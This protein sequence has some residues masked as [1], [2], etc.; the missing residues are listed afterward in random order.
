MI[1]SDS[2][3]LRKYARV[4]VF[5]LCA[6]AMGIVCF[7]ISVQ[8]SVD[9]NSGKRLLINLSRQSE[10][11]NDT[12]NLHFQFLD[13]IAMKLAESDDLLSDANFDMISYVVDSTNFDRVAIIDGDGNSYYSDG[14]TSNVAAR[15]YFQDAMKGNSS[16]SDS[17]LS[18]IDGETKVILAVPIYKDD[19]IIG[20]LGG[21]YDIY[22]LSH[23][24]FEDMFDGIGYSII[25]NKEGNIVTYD[26]NEQHRGITIS[27]NFFIISEKVLSEEA[28]QSK[29]SEPLSKTNQA[30]LL[31]SE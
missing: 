28:I 16:V 30:A 14:A 1:K 9:I 27:N 18:K 22:N 11:L 13:S 29:L 3:Q 31:S 24:L 5:L 10:H 25:V 26:G 21:S 4:I 20:V 2:I 23:M 6:V 17:I 12:L 8:K 7:F 15:K 19:V